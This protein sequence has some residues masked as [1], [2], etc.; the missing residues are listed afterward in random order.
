MAND[1]VFSC[2][3]CHEV[4]IRVAG[5]VVGD[6]DDA[7]VPVPVT[8]TCTST[9]TEVQVQ[10]PTAQNLP[11]PLAVRPSTDRRPPASTWKRGIAI[12]H[13][14]IDEWPDGTSQTLAFK[15]TCRRQGIDFAE[16][17]VDGRPLFARALDYAHEQRRKRTAAR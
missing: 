2:P 8:S 12:A 3:H 13:K 5:L 14:V 1:V 15:E 4:L 9:S 10:R 7:A 16:P 17:G 11:L 6:R